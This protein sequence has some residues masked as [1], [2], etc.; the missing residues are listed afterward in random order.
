LGLIGP[1]FVIFF[2]KLVLKNIKERRKNNWISKQNMY[3]I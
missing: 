3:F 1:Q 2:N